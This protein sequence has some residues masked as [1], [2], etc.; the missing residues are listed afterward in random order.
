MTDRTALTV[1]TQPAALADRVAALQAQARSLAA[2]HV[3]QFLTALDQVARLGAEIAVGGDAYSPG[4]RETARQIADQAPQAALN[5]R[6][7]LGRA[8]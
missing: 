2:E 3:E 6:A 1:V 7:L 8:G 5:V 4:I